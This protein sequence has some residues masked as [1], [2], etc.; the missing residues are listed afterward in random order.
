MQWILLLGEDGDTPPSLSAYGAGLACAIKAVVTLL[1]KRGRIFKVS[2]MGCGSEVIVRDFCQASLT[3]FP[4][5]RSPLLVGGY[6][7]F[8]SVVSADVANL[9]PPKSSFGFDAK[10]DAGRKMT[11]GGGSRYLLADGK[12][13]LKVVYKLFKGKYEPGSIKDHWAKKEILET[14]DNSLAT[15][16]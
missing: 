10:A 4:L 6:T 2:L 11:S 12:E 16:Q 9:L 7:K 14:P 8:I 15:Y 1:S 5:G 3:Q 13:G